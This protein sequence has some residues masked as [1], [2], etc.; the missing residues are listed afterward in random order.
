MGLLA[1]IMTE[2]MCVGSAISD[3]TRKVIG[4]ERQRS[5]RSA[6]RGAHVVSADDVEPEHHLLDAA[7]CGMVPSLRRAVQGH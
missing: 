2:E 4:M 3:G 1:V 5:A 6:A 7:L